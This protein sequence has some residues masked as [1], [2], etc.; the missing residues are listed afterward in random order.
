LNAS[1]A[2][3]RALK[4]EGVDTVFT[5]PGEHTLP[6]L[7]AA[8]REV[9]VINAKLE[10]SAAF[11]ALAHA[12]LRRSVGILIAISGPGLIGSASPI[13]EALVEGD[14]L[15]VLATSPSYEQ[16]SGE[17]MHKLL[18]KD[19]QRDVVRPLTKAQF[20]LSDPAQ[21]WSTL[22][23]AF[24]VAR[25][26]KP[27]PVY[28]EVPVSLLQSEATVPAKYVPARVAKDAPSAKVVERI[29]QM[30]AES[31]RPSIIAG[32][33][34][35]L[36]GAEEQI[37]RLSGILKAPVMTTIMGKGIV[38]QDSPWYGGVAAG[39][40]G[41]K[42]ARDILAGSDVVLSVGNRFSEM[43]TGRFTIEVPAKLIHVNV[44]E[45]D[46]GTRY[47]PLLGVRSDA[48]E[49]LKMLI[50]RLEARTSLRSE[51]SQVWVKA[52]WQS[53]LNRRRPTYT[54]AEE[55]SQ[56]EPW[57]V[58]REIERNLSGGGIVIGD[59]GAH[60]IETFLMRTGSPGSY[61][62]TTSYVSMGLAVP[63]AVAACLA[64]PRRQVVAVV[65]DGAFLMTGFEISTAV[66]Y[67]L[68]PKV[69]VFN[70]SSYKVLKVYEMRNYGEASATIC[71]LPRTDFA[72]I[73]K[74]L[75][76]ASFRVEDRSE[77]RAVFAKAFRVRGAPV[78]IEVIVDPDAV[79]LP[80]HDLYGAE[81][82]QDIKKAQ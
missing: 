58:V 64:F 2:I 72:Q 15:V 16:G 43:G 68:S 40:S 56:I 49:F 63:S 34:V 33:G 45:A 8:G 19:D 70:D 27:G 62:T 48:A 11:M 21:V 76:A 81:K 51:W 69:V 78:V 65:G 7:R 3:V 29:G 17:S 46:M 79:P 80:F 22:A 20:A 74:G 73:A 82:I 5:V 38:P 44:S 57:L 61:M 53:E 6:L 71:D 13:A 60:R 14:S 24:G 42:V 30:L 4:S 31:K 41:D 66:Q 26:G 12:R 54:R 55:S 32:R 37:L 77:L 10:I 59:V 1:D 18:R 47:R 50:P 67:G 36:S 28:V 35:Y 75:G 23:Q 9:R 25:S 52:A 39:L